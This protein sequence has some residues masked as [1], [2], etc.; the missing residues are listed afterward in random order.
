MIRFVQNIYSYLKKDILMKGNF[1][2]KGCILTISVFSLIPMVSGK[3]SYL[4]YVSDTI[5]VTN[6]S[7]VINGD[8]TNISALNSS[9]GPD[10]VSFR[11]ALYAANGTSGQKTIIF[12]SSL[13]GDTI[14]FASDGQLLTLSSGGL[15]INGDI[16]MDGKPDITLDGHLGQNGTPTGPG[17]CIVSSDN[18]ITSLGF[19]EFAYSAIIIACIDPVN[20]TKFFADNKFINNIIS[21]HQGAGITITTLG[22]LSGDVAPMLSDITWQGTTIK[23][24]TIATKSRAININPG[25]G[26]GDRNQMI[27]FTISGNH[28]S[29]EGGAT[30]GVIVA[31]VNSNYFGVPGPNDYSDYNLIDSLSIT[32][33]FIEAPYGQGIGIGCANYSN[34]NNILRNVRINSNT[35]TNTNLTGISLS[36]GEANLER[37]SE[38]NL[39]SNVE[40]TQNIISQ[41][42]RG[43]SIGVGYQGSGIGVNNNRLE[44][45]LISENDISDFSGEGVALEGGASNAEVVLGNILDIVTISS[46]N[47]YQTVSQGSGVGI[48][49]EGGVSLNGSALQNYVQGIHIMNNQINNIGTG[50][51]IFGGDGI[52]AID[53]HVILE[54][55]Y[56][57]TLI[58]NTVPFYIQNNNNGATNNS[59][60][61][62]IPIITSTKDGSRCGVGTVTLEAVANSGTINWYSA[63]TGGT[64]LGTGTSFTTPSLSKTTTYY[65]DATYLGCTTMIRSA[66]TATIECMTN[67]N[68]FASSGRI[69]IYPN[70]TN[71]NLEININKPFEN[72]S[73]IELFN[74]LGCLI[75]AI[76]ISKDENSIQFDLSGYHAG[77]YSIKFTA[78]QEIF[79][80]KIIKK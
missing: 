39:I 44:N 8:I 37:T 49:I 74:N 21:S 38:S 47:I 27:N 78:N 55:I 25:V 46:N 52:G 77:F 40:I 26:G 14:I 66:V 7:D 69:R 31:D 36:V 23:G 45:A 63:S 71:G 9:P 3:D 12:H 18:T 58:N 1:L 43:I 41:A 15:T 76:L 79:Q 28:L 56:G 11:E 30:L 42:W 24:N 5:T 6:V 64:S 4:I 73:K 65:V 51:Q 57:N 34:R 54:E 67:I 60:T 32:N 80:Y 22:L 17:L 68:E 59:C 70:P 72:V 10:G 62:T 50:I 61:P 53:N 29:S 20:G 19:S 16:N 35:I 48:N 33:N 13:I 75:K 2:I